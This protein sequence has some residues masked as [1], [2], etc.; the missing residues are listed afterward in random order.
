MLEIAQPQ[1]FPFLSFSVFFLGL[2]IGSFINSIIYRLNTGEDFIIKRSHCPHCGH[3]LNWNDLVPILSFILLR[4]KCRYCQKPISWQY[5]LVELTTGLLFVLTT[6]FFFPVYSPVRSPSI[7]LGTEEG[8]LLFVIYYLII[9]SF[10]IITFVYDLKHY[11]IPDEVVY[12]AIVLSFLAD[13]FMALNKYHFSDFLGVFKLI[14]NGWLAAFL[15][16]GFF[17]AIILFSHGK[18]MGLGDVKL[19][20]FMG[21]VLGFPKILLALLL[22]FSFGA[23]IGIGLIAL[24][25]KHLKSEI[26][27]GPFLVTGT[28]IAIFWGEQLLHW[29]QGFFV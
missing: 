1:Y 9:I 16:A 2:T 11:L 5:P 8:G 15:A 27:F 17:M 20:V 29:Y 3:I 25:K 13:I 14:T 12:P 23:I 28:L 24:G 22:A 6:N 18:W 4:G 10:L 7:T 21:L 26:P 19:A